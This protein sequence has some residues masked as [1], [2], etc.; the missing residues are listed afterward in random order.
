MMIVDMVGIVLDIRRLVSRHKVERVWT[1]RKGTRC[2]LRQNSMSGEI[3]R[4]FFCDCII[5]LSLA[6][7]VL[8]VFHQA[9]RCVQGKVGHV[10][11]TCFPN[12]V[13]LELRVAL[14]RLPLAVVD[15]ARN[16]NHK[17]P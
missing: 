7:T 11:W 6:R 16:R 17:V 13:K 14:S 4:V 15:L 2:F 3:V 12:A 10:R 1:L 5:R 9:Y 8:S